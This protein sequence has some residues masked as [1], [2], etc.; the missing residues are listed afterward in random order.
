[1]NK[2]EIRIVQKY[3]RD[4]LGNPNILL[5]PKTATKDSVEVFL[6]QEFIA[7]VSRDNEDGDLCYNFHMAILEEDLPDEE[8]L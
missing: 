4:T 1:M 8:D 5:D 6:D 2:T 3:L 7:V